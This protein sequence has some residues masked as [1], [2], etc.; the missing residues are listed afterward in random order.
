MQR[1]TRTELTAPTEAKL[2]ELTQEVV[3]ALN[4]REKAASRW[5]SKPKAAF[6]EIR[7]ALETMAHGRSRCMYCEDG[8]GTDI[9]H[10]RPKADYPDHAFSWPNYLLACSYCNSNLKRNQFPT[11]ARGAPL[12]IDPSV[13]DP[14]QHLEFLST[15]GEFTAL[16]PKGEA[17][18]QVFGLNDE[19]LPRKLPQGRRDALIGL[20]SLL[21]HYDSLVGTDDEQA[22]EIR[23]TTCRYPFGAVRLWLVDVAHR[24]NGSKVLGEKVVALVQRHEVAKWP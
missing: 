17:S 2:A 9:D 1:I 22:A 21:Y 18:I 10:F 12:L 19:K 6:D 20:V 24:T 11:D 13:D 14:A 4:P 16:T 8:Q 7:T 15:T 3:A 5:K 23:V